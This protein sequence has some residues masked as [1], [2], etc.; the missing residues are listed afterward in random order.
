M[1]L[2]TRGNGNTL[3]IGIYSE[4]WVVELLQWTSTLRVALGFENNS[5]HD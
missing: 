5:F 1:Y 4:S 2:V 3:H